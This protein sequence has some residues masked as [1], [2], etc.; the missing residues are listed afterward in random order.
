[1]DVQSTEWTMNTNKCLSHK[2]MQ[3]IFFFF[4]I[5]K[6]FTSCLDSPLVAPHSILEGKRVKY[7]RLH[8]IYSYSQIE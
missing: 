1:M 5:C 3:I 6:S 8:F 4:S 2:M 7:I